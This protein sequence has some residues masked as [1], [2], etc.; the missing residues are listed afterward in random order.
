[1]TSEAAML[2]SVW[3]TLGSTVVHFL[4][5][6]TL[7]GL[8]VGAALWCLRRGSP[9]AR[10]A[11]ASGGM[12]LCLAS[13]L[14]TFFAA[15]GGGPEQATQV[16]TR[17]AAATPPWFGPGALQLAAWS[18][19][20][21]VL[22]MAF[23]F[24][25]QCRGARRLRTADVS[26]PDPLWERAFQD[27]AEDLGIRRSVRLLRSG[28]AEVPMVVGWLSPI[29]LVPASAFTAL[30]PDQ[31]RSLLAH[32]LAHIRR[33]DHWINAAQTVVEIVLFFHPVVWWISKQMRMEREFCCD[34]SSVRQM[35]DPRLIAEALTALEALRIAQP[36]TTT[37]LA[38]NGGPLMQRITRILGVGHENR[39]FPGWQLP[40]T[41]LLSGI[42]ATA[43]YAYAGASAGVEGQA[44][45]QEDEAKAERRKLQAEYEAVAKKLEALVE[46]GKI[47][48]E[49]AHGKLVELRRGAE[50]GA[51]KQAR[52][53]QRVTPAQYERA[54]KDLE[55]A[56]AEGKIG[57]E[58]A[59][60][61]MVE[62]R[63]AMSRRSAEDTQALRRIEAA[64]K[65]GEISELE[66]KRRL[67]EHQRALSARRAEAADLKI[68]RAL[69]DLESA[70]MA[71][72]MTPEEAREKL[73]VYKKKLHS[74]KRSNAVTAERFDGGG[75]VVGPRAARSVDLHRKAAL[76]VEEAVASGK[77]TEEQGKR[78]LEAIRREAAEL[79]A[80][81]SLQARQL[82]REEVLRAATQSGRQELGGVRRIRGAKG[83]EARAA[84]D[85][86]KRIH[87]AVE[88]GQLTPREADEKIEAYE[89]RLAEHR[90]Q[91]EREAR[92]VKPAAAK[93]VESG[94][95][96]R[97]R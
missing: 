9:S 79:A 32:E 42:V 85:V 74:R 31:L 21:G 25:R 53:W 23:R 70:V 30:G 84:E 87:A 39:M 66:A 57:A 67:V 54:Q 16:A 88:A 64:V 92:E 48:K 27:L 96:K 59:N 58:D 28:L 75:A 8:V 13:F 37:V 61:R 15:F 10:Y 47:S 97:R 18:W 63:A 68:E 35:G 22:C 1:M 49:D 73:A 29:V 55:Q 17:G 45:T 41:L 52:R 86:I 81:R 94:E 56:L 40:A 65:A 89:K 83:P 11:V 80:Q 38:S 46:A 14:W 69:V 44:S 90:R 43:G 62:L 19:S 77:L 2:T 36:T 24:T 50:V 51:A 82:E 33:H 95:R 6:G 72:K 34:D 5:Q 91:A 93:P 71:G 12:L 4:W 76:R 20:V 7:I 3:S 78:K 60:R 26:R